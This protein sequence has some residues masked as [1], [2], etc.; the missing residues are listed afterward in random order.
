MLSTLLRS[1]IML[2][3][4]APQSRPRQPQSPLKRLTKT[5]VWGNKCMRRI[6]RYFRTVSGFVTPLGAALVKAVAT[7]AVL[8]LFVVMV[9]HYM[10]VPVPGA[11]ELLRGVERLANF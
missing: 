7:S 2:S 1:A 5:S 8:G 4:L 10:G 3:S 6:R 9:M 11:H